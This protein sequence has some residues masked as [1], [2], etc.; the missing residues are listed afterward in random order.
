LK[1][2]ALAVLALAAVGAARCAAPPRD[3]L[4]LEGNMLTVDN[5]TAQDWKAVEIYLNTYYRVTTSTIRAGSRFQAPLDVFVAGFGQRFDLR[6]MP[7]RS[8]KLTATLPDG[9]PLELN[10]KFQSGGL[11]G[12]LGGKQ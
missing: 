11:A 3:P 1:L 9:Q 10:K 12:A 4:V 6:R 7:I 2:G 5:Q 8:L